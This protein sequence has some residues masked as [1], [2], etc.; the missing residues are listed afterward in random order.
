MLTVVLMLACRPPPPGVPEP[1]RAP[2]VSTDLAALDPFLQPDVWVTP[3]PFVPGAPLQVHYTGVL[4]GRDDLVVRYGWNGW[5]ELE[6]GGPYTAQSG[7]LDN[8]LAFWREEPLASE[9]VERI[10]TLDAPDGARALHLWFHDGVHVDDR[11]A[12]DYHATAE[13]PYVGPFLTWRD[14]T[15]EGASVV[16]SWET[17]V[18]CLGVVS[19]GAGETTKVA[20]GT[21]FDTLHHVTLTG[22]PP[23]TPWTYQVHDSQGQS[24]EPHSFHTP[25]QDPDAWSFVV[26]ADMQ[27]NG[28]VDQAWP[29]VATA[30]AA[31]H[32]DATFLFLLGDLAADDHPG[33]WWRFFEGGRGLFAS[34]PIVVTPGNHDT[35]GTL[36]SPDTRS[37][38]RWFDLPMT[39]GSEDHYAVHHGDA[40]VLA[41]SSEDPDDLAE[42]GRAW[43]LIE[44]TLPTAGD[45][46]HVFLGLHHPPWNAG[47]AFAAEAQDYRP[48][49]ALLDGAADWV[50]AGHEHLPQRFVPMTWADGE[51]ASYGR[52]TEG[53]VGYLVLPAAGSEDLRTALVQEGAAGFEQRDLLAWPQVQEGEDEAPTELGWVTVRVDGPCH[54]V[55]VWGVGTALAPRA[56]HLLDLV[57]CGVA[58]ED[59]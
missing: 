44:Q 41:L 51:V 33:L 32:A 15:P 19:H 4:A 47:G 13:F 40:L 9:G 36:S 12:R 39:W 28:R 52:G 43:S 10:V 1:S 53:G 54:D 56:P 20:V 27:D 11:D 46:G 22:L 6:G 38:R 49:T 8:S 18:P 48:F 2:D 57:S 24:S 34:T 7:P 55:E 14:S 37:Y 21:A 50:F 3:T 23:D 29:Q 30:I 5:A 35:P 58:S 26:A 42:G 17:A 59:R 16:V 25:P 45:P 31:E